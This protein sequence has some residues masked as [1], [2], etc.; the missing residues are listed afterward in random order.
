MR[1]SGK[2]THGVAGHAMEHQRCE[3]NVR[4]LLQLLQ[5]PVALWSRRWQ[6]GAKG[7]AQAS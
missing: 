2:T 7:N 3:Y 6:C 5:L 4:Q 1:E